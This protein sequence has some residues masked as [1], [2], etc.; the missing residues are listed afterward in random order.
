VIA[1]PYKKPFISI[2]GF[3]IGQLINALCCSIGLLSLSFDPSILETNDI[4]KNSY[5]MQY[6]FFAFFLA[7][8]VLLR[9]FQK[10]V[11]FIREQCPIDKA[12]MVINQVIPIVF[13][14]GKHQA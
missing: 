12:K 9:Q 4:S 1:A 10:K 14:T 2:C 11:T 5:P 6:G 3:G 7:F 13:G 8:L